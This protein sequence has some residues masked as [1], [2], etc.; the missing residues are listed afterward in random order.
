L[1]RRPRAVEG[2]GL[3]SQ[4]DGPSTRFWAGKRVFLTGH[5]GFKGSWMSLWLQSL[6][7]EVHGFALEPPTEPNL[8]SV[9]GVGQGMV[10]TIADVRDYGALATSLRHACPEIVMHMAAQSLVRPS[11]ADPVGTYA[12]NVLGTVHLL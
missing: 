1:E 8:F 9:A 6:G 10:S 12:T 7:A 3:S 5:T 11:Y 2:M 4:M